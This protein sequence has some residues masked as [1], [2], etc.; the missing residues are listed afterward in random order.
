ML[1]HNGSVPKRGQLGYDPG[2]KY[3]LV[4]KCM[5]K[6]CNAILKRADQNLTLDETTWGHGGYGEA[7]SG[8]VSSLLNKKSTKEVKNLDL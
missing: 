1:C 2:Y 8:L 6:N 3:N 4:Y 5:T 7:G